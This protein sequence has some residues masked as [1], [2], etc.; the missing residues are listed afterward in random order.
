MQML[1]N[2]MK[3]I[4][5]YNAVFENH[6]SLVDSYMELC[7]NDYQSQISDAELRCTKDGYISEA[8]FDYM[9]EEANEGLM[10]KTSKAVEKTGENFSDFMKSIKARIDKFNSDLSSDK[11]LERIKTKVNENPFLKKSVVQV[12]SDKMYE[13]KQYD[14]MINSILKS[15]TS[16]NADA[17]NDMD[18]QLSKIKK[19]NDTVTV[20]KTL[21]D[22][23]KTIIDMKSAIS[24]AFETT[25]KRYSEI[26]AS[27]DK[28]KIT[29]ASHK[30]QIAKWKKL[31]SKILQR[32]AMCMINFYTSAISEMEKTIKKSKN[33]SEQQMDESTIDDFVSDVDDGFMTELFNSVY[34]SV[35]QSISPVVD[36]TQK[37]DRVSKEF[38]E[39][40]ESC[41]DSFTITKECAEE[42]PDDFPTS[43]IMDYAKTLGFQV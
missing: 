16:D 31:V 25:N 9:C 19:S 10:K 41:M 22:L 4:A 2:L 36:D 23:M 20:Q 21:P 13:S 40:F 6:L 34:E 18:A 27:L 37:S 7:E 33:K 24:G 15:A 3:D 32:K 28:I 5:G 29:S 39:V 38:D 17:L 30:M 11:K 1:D 12:K 26:S 42:T 35:S 43:G 8:S 14:A